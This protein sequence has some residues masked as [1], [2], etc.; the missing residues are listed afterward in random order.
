MKVAMRNPEEL[1]EDELLLF[2]GDT[3][4]PVS[5]FH[6]F[7]SVMDAPLHIESHSS[8]RLLIAQGTGEVGKRL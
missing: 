1:V 2:F 3:H 4:P 7:P 5:H 8:H 6:F